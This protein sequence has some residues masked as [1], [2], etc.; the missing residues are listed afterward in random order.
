M[1]WALWSRVSDAASVEFQWCAVAWFFFSSPSLYRLAEKTHQCYLLCCHGSKRTFSVFLV[2]SWL[3][4]VTCMWYWY[5]APESCMD[6]CPSVVSLPSLPL[7]S[8]RTKYPSKQS[9]TNGNKQEK[10]RQVRRCLT[11]KLEGSALT[12]HALAGGDIWNQHYL[13]ITCAIRRLE[14]VKQGLSANR[15]TSV[16]GWRGSVFLSVA[17]V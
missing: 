2:S 5:D 14:D 17:R 11:G 4:C 7:Y 15:C 13:A 9:K 16:S 3:S 6:L 1:R 10:A 12:E 8:L